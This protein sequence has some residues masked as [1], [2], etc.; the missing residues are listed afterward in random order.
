MASFSAHRR[1]AQPLGKL[2]NGESMALTYSDIKQ[3]AASLGVDP[4]FITAVASNES[5]NKGFLPDGRVIIRFEK[6]VFAR[7]L[8]KRGAP[9]KHIDVA[10]KFT[11]TSWETL[12]AA[13]SLN[14]EAAL[15]S[16]SFGMFQIMGFNFR[17][18]GFG[19]VFEFVQA[20]KESEERQLEAFC[21]F[22]RNEGLLLFMV[23]L[24]FAGFARRY[25]GPGYAQNQYDTKLR[26]AFER[27][28]REGK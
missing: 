3:A 15:C 28:K 10:A 6:H 7:E 23:G 22:A 19:S 1:G 27:C 24:D 4:C 9:Q 2:N 16:T 17:N 20:Q 14:E 8:K 21:T 18:A 13:I 5:A 26:R 11:G 25:N 12:N